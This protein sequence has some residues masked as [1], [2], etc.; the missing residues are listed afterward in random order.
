M[1]F[2]CDKCNTRYS[3]A[4]ERVHGRVLKIRCKA[5]NHVITVREPDAAPPPPLDDDEPL[6]WAVTTSTRAFR[7]ARRRRRPPPRRDR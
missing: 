4:D 5:C 2:A 7:W 6:A 3:I 1:K